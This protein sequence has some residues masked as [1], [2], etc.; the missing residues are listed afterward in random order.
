M[1]EI[2]DSEIVRADGPS[3]LSITEF[4]NSAPDIN[5]ACSSI[6]EN[7]SS[8]FLPFKRVDISEVYKRFM[9]N[10]Q[11]LTIEHPS[12]G[13]IKIHSRLLGQTHKD[14]LEV[15]LTGDKKFNKAT[16]K[17]SVEMSF[18]QILKRLG[19]DPSNKKWLADKINEISD[20]RIQIFENDTDSIGIN[21]KFIDPISRNKNVDYKEKTVKVV[22]TEE[23]TAFLARTE[24]LDYSKYIDDIIS[25]DNTFIKA[26]VRFMLIN[27]GRNSKI[28]IS[29]LIEKLQTEKIM[30]K[31]EL[32][33]S[34][35]L[36]KNE[37]VM[38]KLEEKFGITLVGDETLVFNEPASKSH[39]Y[40]K[41]SIK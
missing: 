16:K 28:K 29:N 15:L 3:S 41:S 17:F 11:T 31:L 36:L 35:E 20:C 40:I 30:S 25:L 39:Y 5:R 13:S 14:I 18:Y 22:F 7:S 2:V 8:I 23:Y 9:K 24:I 1:S 12:F 34:I 21:F 4:I 37:D 33:R 10:N 38:K 32:K 6:L 27:N 19:V 26:V